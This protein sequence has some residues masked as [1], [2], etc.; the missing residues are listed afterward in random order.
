M[1]E[2]L[3]PLIEDLTLEGTQ[4]IKEL[5]GEK[6]DTVYEMIQTLWYQSRRDKQVVIDGKRVELEAVVDE[7]VDVMSRMK[8]PEPVGVTEAPKTRVRFMRAMQQGKSMLR[9]IEHWADGMDGATKTGKGLIGSVVLERDEIQA[10][11]FTRYIWL[12]LIHI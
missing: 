1:Y 5:T 10:G 8:T 12:S 4:D 6:F 11:A 9:R 2:Q 7:L 3:K